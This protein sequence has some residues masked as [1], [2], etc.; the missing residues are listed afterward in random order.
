MPNLSTFI[1]LINL[2]T[3]HPTSQNEQEGGKRPALPMEWKHQSWEEVSLKY[4]LA[5]INSHGLIPDPICT[6][7]P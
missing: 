5:F 7:F 2:S 4:M 1:Y 3:F 6:T